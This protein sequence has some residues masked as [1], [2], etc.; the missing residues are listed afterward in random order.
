MRRFLISAMCLLALARPAFPQGHSTGLV[1]DPDAGERLTY[2]ARPL[3]VTIKVDSI[4]AAAAHLVAGTGDLRGDE[5]AG[6]HRVADEII[7]VVDGWGR[8]TVGAD[9]IPLGPGSIIHVPPAIS[10]RL[11]STGTKPLKY[12]FVLGPT[13]YAQGL[14]NAS[15]IGCADSPVVSATS[16][17]V[18]SAPTQQTYGRGTTWVDPGA[19]DRIAYCLF[20]LT[21]TTKVDSA[22]A[23]GT[24][25][26]AAAGSLRHGVEYA[27]HNSGDEVALFTH[28]SGRAFIGTD[29]VAVRAGS[30]TYVPQGTFHGFINDGDGTLEYIVVYQRGFSPAGFR[31][32]ASRPGPYCPSTAP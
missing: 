19:G 2:C 26:T 5:G 16:P 23:P 15:K 7:Y 30:V 20:P 27:T 29:T 10:H 32:L 12:F 11:V 31:R 18:A 9:T 14:R 4:V 17:I 25:L 1:V 21:I 28:G 3:I 24:R 13:G 22:S 8:A 6:R